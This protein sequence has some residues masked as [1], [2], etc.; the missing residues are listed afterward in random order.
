MPLTYTGHAPRLAAMDDPKLVVDAIVKACIHPKEE[1]PVGAKAKISDVLHH[2]F[3]N[4][5]ERMTATTPKRETLKGTEIPPT[6][7]T[8]FSPL[9]EDRNVDGGIRERKKQEDS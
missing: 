7:G 3:S 6:P 8:A 1:I 9:D 2:I 5:A 4:L